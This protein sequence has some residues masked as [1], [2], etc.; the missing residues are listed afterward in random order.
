MMIL[1]KFIYYG[2]SISRHIES[3]S[4][5]IADLCNQTTKHFKLECSQFSPDEITVNYDYI[6]KGYAIPANESYG[7]YFRTFNDP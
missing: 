4:Q 7:H 3:K 1:I 5:E 6:G 2:I